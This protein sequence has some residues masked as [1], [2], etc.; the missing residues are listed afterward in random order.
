MH[1]GSTRHTHRRLTPRLALAATSLLVLSCLAPAEAA[2]PYAGRSL[3]DVLRELSGRGLQ[4]I[5]NVEL[6][7]PQL[8]VGKEPRPGPD[9]AILDQVL[10]EH[11]LQAQVVGDG[12]FA[13]VRKSVAVPPPAVKPGAPP[14]LEAIVVTASRYS[15][16]TDVPDAHQFLTQTEVAAM[17]RF[18]DDALKAVHR[19]PGAAS[20]GMSGLAHMRGGEENETE[21]VFDGLPL[22]QPF[23]LRLIQSPTSVL[24][25]R[26][27]DSMDV[28]TGGFTA[29]YGDRMSSVVDIRSVHPEADQHYEL[30][31]SNFHFNGLAA[32][33][34]DDGQ[35]QWLAALR[36]SNLD[37]TADLINFDLGEPH[38]LDGYGRLDYD[39]NEDTHASLH[40]LAARD[41]I[42]ITNRAGTESASAHYRNSYAWA[43]LEHRF[44]PQLSGRAQLSF[45]D[46]ESEREGVVDDPSNRLGAFDDR[47]DNDVLGIK[48]DGSW[49]G[50]RWLH[51]FGVEMRSLRATYDYTGHVNF[52][53]GYPFPDSTP[54]SVQRDLA[55]RPTGDYYAAYATTRVRVTDD[56]T[57][58]LGLRWEDAT[59][60]PDAG[61]ELGP[62]VNLLYRL[63]PDTRLRASWGRYL[64]FQGIE[65]LQVEDGVATFHTAQHADHAVLGA[66]HDFAHGFGLRVE[67]YRKEYGG[68][69]TRY[70][71]LFDPLSLA[72][73]LRWDRVAI[74][75][76]SSHVEGVE[77]LL[78]RRGEGPW[79]GWFSYAWSR[80]QDHVGDRDVL[81]SWDQTNTLQGGVTWA[82]AGWTVTLA[83]SYHTGWPLTPVSVV[84]GTTGPTVVLG[85]R[86]TIRYDDFASLDVR[87][88]REFRFGRSTLDVFLEVTNLLDR[89]NPCCVDYEFEEQDDGDSSVEVSRQF[90]R[91]LPLVPSFG[92][93]WKFE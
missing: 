67:A 70:E 60:V 42:D 68:L 44:S 46:V 6:V 2:A 39:F 9:V 52:F 48:L 30:G 92:V 25:E 41:R 38:Y 87:A 82:D 34:F 14:S 51:R 89:R 65:E 11:G 74:Q 28:Y 91:W 36:A 7:P 53:S 18:A 45:T 72:P 75:P 71:S 66:E 40:V 54:S 85:P 90:R 23:H 19:L 50:E 80:A 37:L 93:L 15:L 58:E 12:I 57:A 69:G 33:R 73:E 63:S 77:A 1:Q 16:A 21:V 5:Y 49:S 31:I 17:P 32:Q 27:V 26:V 47:R 10:A 55:P 79:S 81:R 13:I 84:Q 56:L 29:E 20:N 76:R 8:R 62:R 43:T 86:N 61:H 88:S 78:S 83:G 64:Q 35:G 59:Y 3:D 22:I 24:D 4:L